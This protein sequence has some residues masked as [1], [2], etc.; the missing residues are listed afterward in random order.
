MESDYRGAAGWADS[1]KS[2]SSPAEVESPDVASRIKKGS[3]FAGD[4]VFSGLL[5]SLVEGARNAGE[6]QIGKGGSTA[7][8]PGTDMVNVEG[9]FLTRLGESAVFA[10]VAGPGNDL[11]PERSGNGHGL[12][13]RSSDAASAASATK[14]FQRAQP[15]L[16]LRVVRRRSAARRGPACR[17][18]IAVVGRPPWAGET[19][20]SH[21]A[22]TLPVGLFLTCLNGVSGPQTSE[23][24]ESCPS[25]NPLNFR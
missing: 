1:N 16:R 17:A 24:G 25:S 12:S 3:R 10:T 2:H 19:E 15:V 18:G 6:C 13:L 9:C 8:V 21:P 7:C 20:P 22:A 5:G 14:A 23:L 11:R 4:R